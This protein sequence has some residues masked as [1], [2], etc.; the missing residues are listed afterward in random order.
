MTIAL[1]FSRSVA[2]ALA[3]SLDKSELVGGA[4]CY[5]TEYDG[6]DDAYRSS[7]AALQLS[8][9]LTLCCEFKFTTN[10]FSYALGNVNLSPNNGIRIETGAT[11]TLYWV[12]YCSA[13][14]RQASQ[15]ATSYNT[16]DWV[17]FVGICSA[18]ETAFWLD[19]TKC[20]TVASGD[21]SVLASTTDFAIGSRPNGTSFADVGFKNIE[22]YNAAATTPAGWVYDDPTSL[23]LTAG[24]LV[25]RSQNGTGTDNAQSLTFTKYGDPIT[26]ECP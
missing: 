14:T 11:G 23:G 13:G 1:P 15:V 18:A 26:L 25:L 6:I 9:Y 17:K 16:G 3:L 12:A 19:G 8:G 7:D 21:S 5:Y 10:H 22:F 2:E 24:N 4:D 20:P